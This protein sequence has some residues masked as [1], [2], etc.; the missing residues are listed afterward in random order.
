MTMY[1][2]H[3]GLQEPPFRI[4]P[5]TD[6]FFAGARRGSLLDA[7]IY[8]ISHDEGIIKVSG[9]VG[10]GK[11]MLCRMLMER[12]PASVVIVYLANPSLSRKDILWAIAEEL[13]LELPTELRP[14]QL[15]RALQEK[16]VELYGQGRRVVVL[17]DE[18]HAMPLESL[19]E[20]RLLSNLESSRHKLMQLVL[21]GQPEL[22]LILARPDMRQLRERITHNFTLEPLH[23][24]DVGHYLDF[25]MRAAGY[26]GP[27]IFSPSAVKQ[28]AAASLGLTRRINILAD[29]CLLAAYASGRHQVTPREVRNAIA[30]CAFAVSIRRQPPSW[31]WAAA[32]GALLSV[33]VLLPFLSRAPSPSSSPVS[34]ASTPAVHPSA[35]AS[36]PAP[37]IE[38]VPVPGAPLKQVPASVPRSMPLPLLEQTLADSRPW[39]E[40]VAA[41]RWFL[42][43]DT[44]PDAHPEQVENLLQRLREA[45][46]DMAQVRVY[47]SSLSGSARYG[48]I[49]GDFVSRR[50]ALNA[51]AELPPD[52]Q[53]RKPYPRQAVRLK[54]TAPTKE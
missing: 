37:A 39:L 53:A 13:G 46:L 9:E 29:K 12:L 18:A 30:D 26:K 38:R 24:E 20:I 47:H 52:I 19:E 32:G 10:S 7:L 8:A 40:S 28:I 50:Q 41:N 36:S 48:V 14:N 16:L 27:E 35:T 33:L 2:E 49:Y 43:L 17:I 1:L 54:A 5:H 51:L 44:I 34:P 15:M 21:F 6:F 42:Q 3:F 25:R 23:C 45:E 31:G 22:E 4:T 11:T